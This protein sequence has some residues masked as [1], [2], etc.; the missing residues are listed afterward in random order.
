M[1]KILSIDGG[2]I[3]GAL[4]ALVLEHIEFQTGKKIA[5]CFDLI[6]GTSTGGILALATSATDLC[7]NLK[8]TATDIFKMYA[9]HGKEIFSKSTLRDLITIG[10]VIDQKYA[11]DGI[12]KILKEYLTETALLSSCYTKTFVTTYD[13]ENRTP[14]FLKSW[15]DDT[16]NTLMWQAARGTSAAPTYFEPARVDI[17][18]VRHIL[19]DGGVYINNPAM[20]AYVEAKKLFPGEELLIVSLG[21][22]QNVRPLKYDDVKDWGEAQWISP[23]IDVIF[24]GQSS[25][26]DYQ[27]NELMDAKFFRFQTRLD[28]ASDSMD[29]ASDLNINKLKQQADKLIAE[30]QADLNSVCTMLKGE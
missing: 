30:R 17:N 18:G 12:R 20:S 11:D 7:G 24:D 28:I 23:L 6:C 16:C 19:I 26:V 9:D 22:G 13:I 25:V 1:R 14:L 5:E 10:G 4:P 27:I 8:F 29:D 21:T 15:K 3:K 2:G